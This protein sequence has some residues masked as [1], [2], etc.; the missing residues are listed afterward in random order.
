MCNEKMR[1]PNIELRETLLTKAQEKGKTAKD[2]SK[3]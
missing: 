1:M 3:K 2:S